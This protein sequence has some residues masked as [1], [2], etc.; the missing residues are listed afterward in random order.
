MIR[1]TAYVATLSALGSLVSFLN[2][3]VIAHLFGAGADLDA[4][5]VGISLPLMIAALAGGV[6][7]YQ[8]VPAL[9]HEDGKGGFDGALR[10][11]LLG[12]GGISL[13]I[14]LVGMATATWLVP[15][16]GQEPNP[17]RD[18]AVEAARIAWSWLPSAAVG[19]ILT[20]AL[21]VRGRFALATAVQSLP[22]VGAMI[23]CLLGHRTPGVVSLAWG[24]LGGYLAMLVLLYLQLA[25]VSQALRW[26]QTRRLMREGP[27]AL[28]ALLVFVIYPFSDAIWGPVA[29]SSGVSLLGYA[30]RLIV[31]FSG[32]AVVGATTVIFPRLAKHASANAHN[33]LQSDLARALRVMFAFIAPG[34]TVFAAL[35]LPIVQFLLVRGAFSEA[36]AQNLATLLPSMLVGMVAMSGMGLVF[37][38]LFAQGQVKRAA[39]FSLTGALIYF[40]ASGGLVHPLGLPGIGLAYALTWWIILGISAQAWYSRASFDLAYVL[41]LLTVTIMCGLPPWLLTKTII[42]SPQRDALPLALTA[43]GLAAMISFCF[44]CF[45]WPGLA[46]IQSIYHALSARPEAKLKANVE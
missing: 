24:Q 22:A 9:Q 6:L 44:A 2:Q 41:R 16:I 26:T 19:A 40:S 11:L 45:V 34:A 32:L 15:M 1:S 27:L 12:I 42:F 28:G 36:D 21:H 20:G 30:Q 23:G 38:A 3:L 37:K 35:A 7:G 25:P 13:V 5:F 33:V 17:S 10:A 39:L 4:Y 46:E 31:G 43:S 8:I 14:S 18:L 29:G